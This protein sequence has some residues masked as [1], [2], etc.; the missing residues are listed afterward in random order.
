MMIND[1][2]KYAIHRGKID[3]NKA[4]F[5]DDATVERDGLDIM[6]LIMEGMDIT[7]ES[8]QGLG[9]RRENKE[10]KK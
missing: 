1:I 9:V 5:F 4:L 10:E 3:N 6:S 7:E 2:Q 8:G